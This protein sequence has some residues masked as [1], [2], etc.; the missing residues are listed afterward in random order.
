[1]SINLK[2]KFMDDEGT[3]QDLEENLYGKYGGKMSCDC[4]VFQSFRFR[5]GS[6][7]SYYSDR[8][9][10]ESKSR[11]IFYFGII[12]WVVFLISSSF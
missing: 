6:I 9:F 7:L 10:N 8:K 5:R 1:M 2:L 11:F 12:L 4:D 3:N